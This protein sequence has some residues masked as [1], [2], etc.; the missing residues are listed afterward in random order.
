[1][2]ERT[3][4]ELIAE[5][6]VLKQRVSALEA[7]LEMLRS[8]LSGG[9]SGASAVPLVK[10]NRA[11]RRE[12][13]RAK[14]KKRKQSF[15]RKRDIP[16]EEVPH[17]LDRCPDC[18]RNL[19]GGWEH[20]R[21][22]VIEIPLTPVRIIE[23]VLI[24]RRCGVCGKV[25]IPKLGIAE[26]VVG[27]TRLGVN[28]MSLIATLSV[29][30]RMPQRMIQKLLDG[31]Y[32]L[33]IS[34]GEIS[35]VLH[36]VS[37]WSKATVGQILT[38]IRGS[39]DVSCDETGW[40]ED[41]INGY[42]WSVSTGSERFYYFHRRRASRIIRH[43]LGGN[44]SGVLGCDFYAGY[45][46]Y[47][48]PKQRCWVHLLRDL[49]KLVEAHGSASEW[50]LAVK[51]I[52]KAARKVARRSD[53]SDEVRLRLRE[54]LQTKLLWIAQRYAADKDCPQHA[55]AKRICRYL[56]ELFTFVEH[57]H[58]AWHNNAAERAI[59]PAV[60]ARKVSGGTRSVRG[61]QTKTRLMSVFATWA[62][63]GK[64]P[65]AACAQMI[66]SSQTPAN[67]TAT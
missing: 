38:S 21:R 52:W 8:M 28:L 45:D 10:P 20:S 2:D 13:D 51:D 30:K 46:W 5:N 15:V 14:R 67:C 33:K 39:P 59:R 34:V 40:R 35:E 11:Q 23:H 41:G 42:L 29:A 48:G 24:A 4:E 26:G 56:P 22:Q 9:G 19:S 44:F 50:A 64:Q 17:V 66:I 7:E 3:R 1:V 47:M 49:A 63:Q 58:V 60:I 53:L 43:I 6:G 37:D 61:S 31:L 55:L 16:T 18:G 32:G 25:H 12:A 65:I 57:P 54:Q 36:R 62:L 27:K